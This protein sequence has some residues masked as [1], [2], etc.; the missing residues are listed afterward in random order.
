MVPRSSVMRSG[1]SSAS[2]AGHPNL[3]AGKADPRHFEQLKAM[4]KATDIGA[5]VLPR[6][7]PDR[8]IHHTQ[9]HDR[10]GIEQ[11]E[12]AERV[13]ITEVAPPRHK[14]F[15]VVFRE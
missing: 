14:T 11:F 15:V 2:T 10:C 7:I 8:D 12:I 4:T 3:D 13:E 1:L 9:R 6:Q 5:P